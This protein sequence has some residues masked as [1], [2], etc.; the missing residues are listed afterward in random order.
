MKQ[1]STKEVLIEAWRN[2]N[3]ILIKST[4]KKPKYLDRLCLVNLNMP[5]AMK[6]K[7][8]KTK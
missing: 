4:K 5:L 2:Y 8:K 6:M 7:R 3:K 1:S